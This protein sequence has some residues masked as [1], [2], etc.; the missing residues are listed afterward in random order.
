M[1]NF[2]GILS[3]EVVY[4]ARRPSTHLYFGLFFI[5][6]ALLMLAA[7]GALGGPLG[8]TFGSSTGWANSAYTMA[9]FVPLLSLFG[10]LVTAP[11]LGHAV[12][13]DYACRMHPLLFSQPISRHAF[14]AGRF[15][16]GILANAWIFAGVPLGM[17][18]ASLLPVMQ[19]DRLGPFR[20]A[21]FLAPYLVV[22]V[23][24]LLFTGALFFMLAAHT[25]RMLPNY[26]GGAALLVANSFAA[27]LYRDVESLPLAALLDPFAMS[28]L[29]AV[30]RYWT[31][32]EQN[33][34]PFPTGGP[35]LLNRAIWLALGA[36]V[37]ALGWWR[38]RFVEVEEGGRRRRPA[39]RSAPEELGVPMPLRP[40]PLA[41]RSFSFG[42][43]VRQYLSLTRVEFRGIVWDVYFLAL[44]AVGLLASNPG[45]TVA[46]MAYGTPVQPATFRVLET[47]HRSYAIL[48][49]IVVAL[50]AGE[51]L[52]RDRDQRVQQVADSM[53]VPTGLLLGAKLTA[54][55]GALAVMLAALIPL[56]IATQA[57]FG[58]HRF[59]VGLYL[60]TLFG[61]RLPEYVLFAALALGVHAVLN[62]KIL[63]H[64]VVI[65]GM[66]VV[67]NLP[68]FGIE[69]VL[70][71]FGSDAGETYSELLGYGTQLA[72]FFWLKAYWAGWALLLLVAAALF[73]VRGEQADLATRARLARS[74]AGRSHGFAALGA[75]FLILGAGGFVFYNTNVLNPYLSLRAEEERSAEYERTY[76]RHA[77]VA[78]PL[79]TRTELTVDLFPREQRAEVGAT[80]RL[81]N[82]SSQAIDTL[83]LVFAPG[84][85]V[86]E[87]EV[88]GARPGKVDPVHGYRA[89]VFG[90][91]LEPGA[92]ATLRYAVELRHRGFANREGLFPVRENGTFL[93]WYH[94]EPSF[95]YDYGRELTDAEAR[96]RYGLPPREGPP[97]RD[98]PAVASLSIFGSGGGT[99]YSATISTD[100]DQVAVAPGELVSQW[101][102]DG[103]AYFRYETARPLPYYAVLSGRWAEARDRWGSVDIVV[104]YHPTHGEHVGRMLQAVRETLEYGTSRFGPFPFS[105][106]AI[107][108]M[109]RTLGGAAASLPGVILYGEDAGFTSRIREGDIDIPFY[110]TAHEVGHH[111]WG[112]Q[113]VPADA[114]GSGVLREALPQYT[115]LMVMKRHFGRDPGSESPPLRDGQVS[116]A[117][118]R[119][120]DAPGGLGAILHPLPEGS[121]RDVRPPGAPGGRE[122]ERS[123]SGPAEGSF[124]GVPPLPDHAGPHAPL[125]G[126]HSRLPA[127]VPGGHL[128]SDRPL[129]QPHHHR[130]GH[131]PGGRP[132]RPPGGRA[133][134]EDG[135]GQHRR[136]DRCAHGRIHGPGGLRREHGPGWGTADSPRRDVPPDERGIRA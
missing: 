32:V 127:G 48:V 77:G 74:R 126:R 83:H 108:E 85:S 12:Q 51:L 109:P 1:R 112:F 58:Y 11:L 40:L 90:P 56:G 115:A 82:R 102:Q 53:P 120:R 122:G 110:I 44:T 105:R 93:E 119:R 75:M 78:Q 113:L 128:R 39:V 5:S 19:P 91:P 70:F 89:Y 103:R 76:R 130:G 37:L 98:A 18:L 64:M 35:V 21:T 16:G 31:V 123:P 121:G 42:V 60:G 117:Q 15:T 28:S 96:R 8:A 33:T 97:E 72:P 59:Q 125:Q 29:G 131:S 67:F 111:W 84:V 86:K 80:Q 45:S 66:V 71:R 6:S 88:T 23:P 41:R 7:G 50:Y 63:A 106:V 99:E 27:G 69:H 54:L 87:L 38:L 104:Y 132:L 65:A 49:V 114:R 100:A 55:A 92:S 30:T 118:G 43:R 3:F 81:E 26:V 20:L 47:L 24:N 73:W 68:R 14:L 107:L 101:S 57:V 129:R 62:H 10:L 36:L 34:L 13:R 94:L 135:S 61:L 17:M 46:G 9:F 134:P 95:G 25:R 79:A 2:L 22:M 52:W 4:Y 133:G 116:G 124:G 136:R